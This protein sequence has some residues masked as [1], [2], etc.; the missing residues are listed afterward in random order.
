MIRCLYAVHNGHPGQLSFFIMQTVGCTAQ[1]CCL[2]K[3]TIKGLVMFVEVAVQHPGSWL[4][5]PVPLWGGGPESC[6]SHPVLPSLLQVISI[7]VPS[8]K[9]ILLIPN[10]AHPPSSLYDPLLFLLLFFFNNH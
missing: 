3:A 5:Y 2:E 4:A 7:P 1:N 10:L 8:T 9:Q 6:F